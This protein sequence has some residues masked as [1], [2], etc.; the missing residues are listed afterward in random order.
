MHDG[1]QEGAVALCGGVVAEDAAAERGPVEG[2]GEAIGPVLAGGFGGGGCG[3]EEE[4]RGGGGEVRDDAVVARRAGLD[5]L[6]GE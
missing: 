6:A 5:D 4:V 3:G 2:A 1:V